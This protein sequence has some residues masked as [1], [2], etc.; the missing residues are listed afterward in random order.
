MVL[1]SS[2]NDS[3]GLEER[4]S[5]ESGSRIGVG[6]GKEGFFFSSLQVLT[7]CSSLLCKS[8]RRGESLRRW[9][10]AYN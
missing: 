4:R 7:C 2:N 1:R 6:V 8:Y 3:C 10:E 5:V 9:Y